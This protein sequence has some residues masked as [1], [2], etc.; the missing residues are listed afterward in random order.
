[1]RVD[2]LLCNLRFLRTRTLAAEFV[3]AGHL[4]RNGTRITRASQEIAIG[5]D[6]RRKR[7]PATARLTGPAKPT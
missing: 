2:R 3:R 4:R 7:A 6:R 5:A 1:M